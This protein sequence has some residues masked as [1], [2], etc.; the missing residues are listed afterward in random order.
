MAENKTSFILY[1]DLINIVEKLP[2]EQAGKLFKLILDYVNDKN[3]VVDDLLLQVA[4]EPIKQQLK[5]D[6]LI[7]EERRKARSEAGKQGNLKR[8]GDKE[9]RKT[10]QCDKENRKTSQ[11]V[12]KIAV[13]VNGTVNGTVNDNDNVNDKEKEIREAP[14]KHKIIFWLEENCPTVQ[15]MKEPLTNEQAAKIEEDFKNQ[16]QLVAETFFAMENKPDLLKKYKSANLTFRKWAKNDFGGQSQNKPKDDFTGRKFWKNGTMGGTFY[17]ALTPDE[18]K[19]K[20]ERGGGTWKEVSE[21]EFLEN[22]I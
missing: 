15:K 13:T 2:D 1:C 12:A 17:Y 18:L 21:A 3:P 20:Q 11:E 10:S 4:F 19:D 5:R 16:S 7:W 8:W 14:P 22:R 6:L 9:N